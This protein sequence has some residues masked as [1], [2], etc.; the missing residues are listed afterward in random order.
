MVSK[1]IIALEKQVGAKLL[2]RNNDAQRELG[3][4]IGANYYRRARQ[5]VELHRAAN[6]AS[7]RHA[8]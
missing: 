1:H 7:E 4:E 5:I 3:S 2:N 8:P 6:Q